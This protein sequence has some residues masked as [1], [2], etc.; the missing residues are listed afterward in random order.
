M[1]KLMS[2]LVAGIL[3]AAGA[4]RGETDP[5][6]LAVPPGAA[7][8]LA[9]AADGIQL[10]ACE[11]TA[12]GPEWVFKAPE[13][14]LFDSEGRQAGTHAAG[15]TWTLDDGSS[16]G[17]NTVADADTSVIRTTSDVAR[18]SSSMTSW[19]SQ[20]FN[21]PD[22]SGASPSQSSAVASL[23]ADR[24]DITGSVSETPDKAAKGDS[25]AP[26]AKAPETKPVGTAIPLDG[27]S[28]AERA[29]LERLQERRRFA[30]AGATE[31][32]AH[33][34]AIFD[35][36]GRRVAFLG[37]VSVMLTPPLLVSVP[38]YPLTESYFAVAFTCRMPSDVEYV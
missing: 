11:A 14:A 21:F 30:F 1:A 31:D 20:M 18:P 27:P 23:P 5:G 3:L 9:F 2:G 24:T 16:A 8:A 35:V 6:A 4:A 28:G 22:G 12:K 10:Y 32:D 36:R 17:G 37:Y 29:I 25:K 33:R 15:P 26:A 13:A 19:A 7:L 34:P 38:E